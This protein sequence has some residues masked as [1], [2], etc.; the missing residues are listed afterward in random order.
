MVIRSRLKDGDSPDDIVIWLQQRYG[1]FIF[2]APPWQPST[3]FLWLSPFALLLVAVLWVV[4][5]MRR[6]RPVP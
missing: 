2:L 5:Y 6:Q 4:L 3:Y 1:H